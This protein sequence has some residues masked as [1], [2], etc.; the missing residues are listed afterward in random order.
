MDTSVTERRISWASFLIG[1][2]LL[3]QLGSLAGG[4]PARLHGVPDDWMPA[5]AGGHCAVSAFPD[6]R[7]VKSL[8]ARFYL[9]CRKPA[10]VRSGAASEK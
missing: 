4:P 8:D 2:G 10:G 1:A 6:P 7:K 5:H 3:V 9:S